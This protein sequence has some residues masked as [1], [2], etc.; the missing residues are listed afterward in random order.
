VTCKL[1]DRLGL[2]EP[3]VATVDEGRRR[4]EPPAWR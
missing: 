4:L 3:G 2:D 1:W